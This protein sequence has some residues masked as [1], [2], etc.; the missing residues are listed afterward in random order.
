MKTV[1]RRNHGIK[2][3]QEKQNKDQGEARKNILKLAYT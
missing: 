3:L 1:G 2:N